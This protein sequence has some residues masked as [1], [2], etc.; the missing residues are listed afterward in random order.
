M[1]PRSALSEA[2][3]WAHMNPPQSTSWLW[4]GHTCHRHRG[5]P[6]LGWGHD[7]TAEQPPLHA[8]VACFCRT[9]RGPLLRIAS[10]SAAR[11]VCTGGA[12]PPQEHRDLRLNRRLSP[13]NRGCDRNAYLRG[14]SYCHGVRTV[15][16]LPANPRRWPTHAR[17]LTESHTALSLGGIPKEYRTLKTAH[18]GRTLHSGR[19]HTRPWDA[20]STSLQNTRHRHPTTNAHSRTDPPPPPQTTGFTDPAHRPHQPRSTRGF[21]F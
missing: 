13:E 9:G 2:P 17:V 20:R 18:S 1:V 16:T 4:V 11:R 10:T 7:A 12:Q 19:R 3:H 6:F 21:P 15:Q 14:R 5:P 8:V